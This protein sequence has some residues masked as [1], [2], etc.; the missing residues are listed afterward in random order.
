MGYNL[1]AHFLECLVGTEGDLDEESL[2]C[3]SILLFVFSQF[4][5]VN[6]NLLEVSF[7]VGVVNFK[8]LKTLCYFIFQISW[9]AFVLLNDFA[10]CVEHL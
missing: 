10:S 7:H 9:L 3:S 5:A 2:A 4:S 6:V 8:L 1:F